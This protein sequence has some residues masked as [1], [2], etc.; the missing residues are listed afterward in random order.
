VAGAQFDRRAKRNRGSDVATLG[1][2]TL[3]ANDLEKAR[4][5][6]DALL[7]SAGILPLFD[8]PSGGRVYGSGGKLV[9]GVLGPY[10]GRPATAGNGTMIAFRFETVEE[11]DDFYRTALALGAKDEGPP[12][13]RAPVFY[14]SYFRDPEGNKLCAFLQREPRAS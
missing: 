4:A 12:G 1:Y 2:A 13:W 9:F 6:Y 14:M 5:F 10:D 11:V 8:H 3:G 7:G